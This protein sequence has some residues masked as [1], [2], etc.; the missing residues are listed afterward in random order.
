MNKMTVLFNAFKDIIQIIV[1]HKDADWT[2][3]NDWNKFIRQIES[4]RNKYTE[5]GERED[6][7]IKSLILTVYEYLDEKYRG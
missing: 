2:N 4:I 1:I 5:L 3:D 6:R 7:L